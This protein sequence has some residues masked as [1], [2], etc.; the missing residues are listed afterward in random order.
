MSIAPALRLRER[1]ASAGSGWPSWLPLVALVA[2]GAD[3]A[4]GASAP[5]VVRLPCVADNSIVLYQGEERENAG[6]AAHIR[7]KGNQHLVALAFDMAPLH[8][9][10]A[11][12]ATLVCHRADIDLG[13]VVV[14][15]IQA[16]WDE[17]A[18]NALTAGIAG[19]DGW[20]VLGMRF[21]A[22]C[23]GNAGSALSAASAALADG[24]YSWRID[25]DLVNALATGCAFGLCVH[26]ATVDYSRNPT[27]CSREQSGSEPYLLVRCAPVDAGE[28]AEP[29][30]ELSMRPVEPGV[31]AVR[32]RAPTHGFAYRVMVGAAALPRWDIPRLIPG[33]LQTIWVRDVV[34][35]K[36][37]PISVTVIDRAGRASS[38]ATVTV[39]APRPPS[40]P[41]PPIPPKDVAKAP[42]R[43]TP[44]DPP[45]GLAVIPLLD[46]YDVGGKAIGALP[47]DFRAHNEVFDGTAIT[48]SAARGEVVG[49][50]VL[51]RGRGRVAVTATVPGCRVDVHRVLLV[52][53]PVG[54]VPDPMIPCPEHHEI[55]LS[56]TEDLPLAVEVYVPFAGS[57]RDV[58]GSFTVSD[59]RSLPIRLHVRSFALPKRATFACEMNGY[60][61]PDSVDE[62]DR[63]Q[64]LAYDRRVHANILHYSHRTAAAGARKCSLDMRLPSGERMDEARYNRIAPGDTHA[65]WD[66]F[67]AAFGPY[68]SGSLFADGHRGPVPAPGFYLTFHESWPLNMRPYWNG[69]LDARAGFAAHPEYA[70]TFVAILQ[71]FIRTAKAQKWTETGF[72][73]FCNN[74]TKPG[75]PAFNP[76][77]LDEPASWWDY[78]ALGFFGDLVRQAKGDHCPIRLDYRID[79]SRPEFDR[80]ALDG[81]AGLWVVAFGAYQQYQRL[82]LDR[83]A[84]TGERLWVYGTTNAVEESNRQTQAWVLDAFSRGA[85]G[86]VPWQT[87]DQSGEAM[88]KGDQLGLFVFAHPE[89]KQDGKAVG[90]TD[91][92]T[93]IFPS[94][95]LDAYLRAEQDVEYL[96][97][98]QDKLSLSRADLRTWMSR[99]LDLDGHHM[100]K[101]QDDAGTSSYGSITPRA[102]TAMREAAAGVIE[103]H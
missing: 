30:S 80:G 47:D 2:L 65:Y 54:R 38:A 26:E 73:V 56:A 18:S 1:I 78:R 93:E 68:L 82:V 100:Q 89:S 3:S 92:R 24:V 88:K 103:G 101:N 7:V 9:R 12:E 11:I 29:A 86:V 60:G 50:Q 76:W 41:M 16:P 70:T 35:P 45:E 15:T 84:V 10:V 43:S 63:L 46:K 96:T 5:E 19:V 79:I 66:D 95:R 13:P 71:D 58:V 31:F 36:G 55:E 77:T 8:G 27:I 83:S 87:I 40:L 90:A 57:A 42:G 97:M 61:L 14:S 25:P 74:K 22:V 81:A 39:T 75:D 52:D 99:Y 6:K 94:I 91:S 64:W 37:E 32:V 53:T 102:F 21:P 34:I 62:F 69:D 48:L 28:R 33:E 98:M 17:Y 72:Q 59:G 4:H 51:A 85:S 23:G 44:E 67:I 49:F 20:G